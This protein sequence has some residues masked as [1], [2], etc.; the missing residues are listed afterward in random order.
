MPGAALPPFPDNIKTHPLLVI[1]YALVKIGSKD[2]I[3]R[4]W[5]AATHLG[6]WYLKNHGVDIEVE[7]MFDTATEIMSLPLEEKMKWDQGDSG[8]SFGYKARGAVVMN[9]YGDTDNVE[10]FNV[11]KEDALAYPKVIHRTYP[12][13]VNARMESTITP[14]VRK[15]TEVLETILSV[16]EKRLG[17][18]SNA[19]LD[20]HPRSEHSGSETRVIKSPPTHMNM[21][22]HV[23]KSKVS[24]GAHTD[25]GSL[26]FLHNRLGGLQV[27]PPGTEE[28]QYI[29]PIPGY[30][31]CNIG[32]SLSLLSGAPGMQ[33]VHPRWSVVFF[34]RPSNNVLLRALD[35]GNIVKEA[36]SHMNSEERAR[37]N[38]GVTQGEWFAR[39]MKFTRL[40]NIKSPE[41]F[42]ASRGMEHKPKAI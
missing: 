23:E 4:L 30:A 13:P 31:I 6:F 26:T 7:G 20:L 24:I 18:R 5:E 19:L 25:F 33:G 9:E 41:T 38:P 21:D 14:F 32:D 40:N 10:W 11:S 42:L 36:L 8:K 22:G 2:E 12:E 28:W 3:D 39:R 15:S 16:F 17:L 1:D 29:L 34:L 35:E 37:Y 27:L